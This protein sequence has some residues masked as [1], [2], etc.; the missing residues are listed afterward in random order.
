MVAVNRDGEVAA[1]NA[2]FAR[3]C[4]E[5]V[6]SESVRSL[7]PAGFRP[8]D[9]YD[10]AEGAEAHLCSLRTAHGQREARVVYARNRD[11]VLATVSLD[12]LPDTAE[13][14]SAELLRAQSVSRQN[15]SRYLHDTVS[16]HL[17]LL[18]LTLGKLERERR[19]G[20]PEE[21]APALRVLDLC[22]R[23]LRLVTYA[24]APPAFDDGE[25]SLAFEWFLG[26]L[27]QDA[28]LKVDFLASEPLPA[29]TPAAGQLLQAVMQEWTGT[30]VRG[31]GI[32]R[33]VVHLRTI[34]SGIGLELS[35]DQL[36]DA[37]LSAVETSTV[38]RA[39]ILATGGSLQVKRLDTGIS[40]L[41]F[42]PTEGSS[43]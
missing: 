41:I 24:L 35:S 11:G 25:P 40:L 16:Q 21:L 3:L 36:D 26:Q 14:L 9:F 12:G 37:A 31:G 7:F 13:G 43:L 15:I 17:V 4:G 2:A 5:D 27:R 30:A 28:G 22:C 29:V 18:A 42:L 34:D 33:T 23:D 1:S 39:R 6:T 38:I 19:A 8:A 20:A 32:G 10:R